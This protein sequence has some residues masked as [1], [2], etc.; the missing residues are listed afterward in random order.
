M[1]VF[2]RSPSASSYVVAVI[3]AGEVRGEPG[4]ELLQ[5]IVIFAV[6]FYKDGRSSEIGP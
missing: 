4:F 2:Y 5:L 3:P 6:S 1:S